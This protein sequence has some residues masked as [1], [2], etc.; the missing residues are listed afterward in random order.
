[1]KKED[2][3]EL[4]AGDRFAVGETYLR[5]AL[6]WSAL[7]GIAGGFVAEAVGL[8]WALGFFGLP[9]LLW[10]VAMWRRTVRRQREQR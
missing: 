7:V 6:A 4:E 1:M 10:A 8:S 2:F 5:M 9:A 3:D